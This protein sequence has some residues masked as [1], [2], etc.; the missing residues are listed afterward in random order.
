MPKL[1]ALKKIV[2]ILISIF[3]AVFL[4][5]QLVKEFKIKDFVVDSLQTELNHYFEDSVQFQMEGI[6]FRFLEKKLILEEVDVALIAHQ[7]D[8]LANI[9]LS[10]IS[11]SWGDFMESFSTQFF[12]F[13]AIE[14]QDA[15]ILLPLDFDKI[16]TQKA[17]RPSF[18]GKFELQIEEFKMG[19]GEIVFYDQRNRKSGRVNAKYNINAENIYFKKGEI[20]KTFQDIAED[21]SLEFTDL[22]YYLRD[23]LHK[24]TIESLAFNLFEQD[25]FM[26]AAH[27][28]PIHSPE[29]FAELKED[30]ASYV[31][32]YFDS[33]Q[34]NLI[35]WQNDSTISVRKVITDSVKLKV[36]KD[37][38]YPLPEDRFIPIIVEQLKKSDRSI[39]VRQC[40]VQN[41]SLTY[42]EIPDGKDEKGFVKIANIN[43]EISNITNRKDSILKHGKYLVINASGNLYDAGLLEADIRYDL[44]SQY[45]FFKVSGSLQPMP[46]KHINNYLAVAYPI[47]I[48]SGV[49]DGLYF[50][51]AGGNK[52]VSGEMQFKYSDLKIDFNKLLNDEEKG[53]NAL[54]WL[55][56]IALSQKNPKKN[57]KY[58]IGEIK[59]QRNV[60]K[61]MF[62]YWTNSLVSGFQSTIGIKDPLRIEKLDKEKDDK[63]I[64]QKIGFGKDEGSE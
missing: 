34:L 33:I 28:R 8:T 13:D 2:I 43:G 51:Y 56:N 37:K 10:N 12:K 62:S 46:I 64:W 16:K 11:L 9:S 49:V 3:T 59:F 36:I 29:K 53:D 6:H 60:R 47:E 58:R 57:G 24:V 25:M 23:D 30:Q 1:K 44:T 63:N 5:W 18:Q 54:S 48:S 42:W 7:K 31:D 27:F 40:V 50:N 35:D 26:T 22:S 4:A 17:S 55:A 45:G 52:E 20:P 21:I 15:M 32:I 61:S 41:M 38:N 39:D 19:D 14:L